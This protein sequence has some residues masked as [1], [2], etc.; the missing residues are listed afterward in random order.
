M[1]LSEF[2][3]KR[4]VTVVV[5][6]LVFITI[7]AISI[8]KLP[9]EMLPDTSFPGLMIQVYYS[10]SSPEE[11]E[12]IIT[13]PMEEILS[14]INN[15]KNIS[16]SSS[17]SMSRIFIEFNTGTNMDLAS[18]EIRDKVDQVKDRLPDDIE[19]IRIRR[20]ST[21]DR[22]IISFSLS[23][24]GEENNLYYWAENFIQPEVERIE[25]VANVDIRGIR[26]KV[27]TIYVAPEQFYSSSLRITDLITTIRNNNINISAGY[28]EEKKKRF[29]LRVPGELKIVDEISNLPLNEMGLKIKDIASVTYD[30]PK[31]DDYNKLNGF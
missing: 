20:W 18:M 13:R 16:S 26:N 29:V 24:P 21:S 14:T 15:L 30:Y 7:G 31:R 11:I 4:P 22:P 28:L 2:S 19:R 17:A 6:M 3:I 25:G 8:L 5:V 10:S 27:L 23:L 12:R 1:S 9:L